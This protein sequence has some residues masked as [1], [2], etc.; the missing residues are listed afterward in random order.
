V[1][2]DLLEQQ[3]AR[4]REAL[5]EQGIQLANLDVQDQRSQGQ[6]DSTN[7]GDPD[8]DA[9][10]EAGSDGVDDAVVESTQSLGLVDHYV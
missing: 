1:V 4:L 6:G 2:R 7:A 8:A 3:A 5:A 9:S 10:T